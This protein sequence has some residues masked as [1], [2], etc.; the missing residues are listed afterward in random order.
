MG[1]RVGTQ[2]EERGVSSTKEAKQGPWLHPHGKLIM[3]MQGLGE[4]QVWRE[5]EQPGA[6]QRLVNESIRDSGHSSNLELKYNDPR[7][8]SLKFP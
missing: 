1:R 7:C 6:R 4:A 3:W 8:K 5:E 2:S